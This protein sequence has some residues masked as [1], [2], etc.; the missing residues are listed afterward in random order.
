[1]VMGP[2]RFQHATESGKP[3][4]PWKGLQ[5]LAPW[6]APYWSTILFGLICMIITTYLQAQPQRLVGYIIDVVIGKQQY[7]RGAPIAEL[8]LLIFA[9]VALFS[10]LRTYWMHAAGQRLIHTLRV[11]LYEHL[12]RLS[13][14]FYDGRQTGDLMSRTTGDTE[15]VQYIV[16]HGLDIF[17]MGIFGMVLMFYYIWRIS[18]SIALLILIPVP[19]IAVSVYFFSRAIRHIYRAIRD[20]IGDLNAKLQD[21]YTGIRVIKAF[22]REKIEL[23]HVSGES[24]S[25]LTMNIHAIRMWSSFGPAMGLASNLGSALLIVAGASALTHTHLTSGEF[26][27]CWLYVLTFYAP[28]EQPFPGVR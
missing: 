4:N 15:Q 17:L 14:T 16:E 3:R 28:V 19:I 7:R 21:N 6:L 11:R 2:R 8:M 25:V 22:A 9:A 1:M 24:Q 13:M 20:R 27:T 5:R 23:E 18:P 26:T 12:Q 10:F